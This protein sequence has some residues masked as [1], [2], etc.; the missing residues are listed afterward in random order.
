M[1]SKRIIPCLDVKDGRTVKGVNFV[2]LRDAGDA[3]ELAAYY[4]E[5]GADELVFLDITAT[6]EKRKTL[7]ELVQKV[8]K[9]LN[10]PFTVGG[11]I[12]TPEDVG[13]LL[14]AGADKVSIN[15]SAVRNPNL[16]SELASR[17]GSQCVVVAV[18]ARFAAGKWEVYL[19][20]GRLATGI[21]L[22]DW[23][24][25]A[26]RLGAGEILFTSMNHDGTK[27]GFANETLAKLS[28]MV[29]IPIIASGG[30]GNRE[31]FADTF[32]EGK[33]DAA[34]AASVFHFKEI[35]IPSLKNYLKSKNIP[36]RI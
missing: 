33:A 20:G 14:N 3:V 1:L 6:H 7:V 24:L 25:E 19:N 10:I 17:F 16:I 23:I 18:D 28:E 2:D 29:N 11:G 34:L 31:H 27:N 8:A 22:F 35:E 5:Q 32:I 30:A 15:S 36:V 21:D 9:E 4:A 12:S 26:E 13:V